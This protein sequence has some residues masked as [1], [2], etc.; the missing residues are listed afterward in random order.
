[1]MKAYVSPMISSVCIS[2]ADI[3]TESL[4]LPMLPVD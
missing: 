2:Q 4:E 3:L 1:M